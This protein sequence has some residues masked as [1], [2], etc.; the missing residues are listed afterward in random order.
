VA[1]LKGE[2]AQ[3]WLMQNTRRRPVNPAVAADKDMFPPAVLSELPFPGQ[4][5]VI[6]SLLLS[7]LNDQRQPAH[8]FFVLDVSGSMEG[9]R[10]TDLRKA[11][12]QLA[13]DD[14]SLT[15]RFARF[16]NRERVTFIPFSHQVEQG[17]LTNVDMGATRDQNETT[18]NSIRQFSGK[19]NAHGGTAMYDAI[20]EA[21][22]R[23]ALAMKADPQ[24]YY[25]IVVMTDGESNRGMTL[26]DFRNYYATMPADVQRVRVFTVLFGEGNAGELKDLAEMTG[27]RAFD[28]RATPLALMFK[29]IRGYQ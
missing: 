22:R 18:L 5:D 25:T 16:Q 19:L 26:K 2:Q 27:G 7:Y 3:R 23:V 12:T 17:L 8:V 24:R 21:Y 28:S 29:G 15:G 20:G 6:N 9:A 13:G 10:I 11:L 1:W 4:I 14:Q